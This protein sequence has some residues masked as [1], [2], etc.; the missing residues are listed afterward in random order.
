[1]CGYSFLLLD[2]DLY[3]SKELERVYQEYLYFG[4][5]EIYDEVRMYWMSHKAWWSHEH[6]V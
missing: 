3:F 4:A 5:Q 2:S 6:L 1:M